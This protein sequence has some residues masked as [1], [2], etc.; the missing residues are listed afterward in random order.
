MNQR[1]YAFWPR[2]RPYSFPIPVT[3]LAINLKSAAERYPK[4]D[5]IVYYDTPI[6][7]ER[8]WRE[9][10]ALAGYLQK[11]VGVK[12]GD[13]VILDMQNSPQWAIAYYAILRANA[14]VVPLN[15]MAVTAELEVYAEDSGATVAFV[16]QELL[17]R[18]RPLVGEQLACV[19]VATYSEYV[20]RATDLT[21]PPAVLAPAVALDDVGIVAWR[22]ALGAGQ[23]PGPVTTGD[24]D[25][26]LL[27]YTSGTTGRPKGCVHT[28]RSVQTTAYSIVAWG[29]AVTAGGK[30]L[31]TLPFFHVTGMTV[32]LNSAFL[33]GSTLIMMTRWDAPTTLNLIE[34]YE[35]D[36]MTAISTMVVDLLAQSD[37]RPE[38]IASLRHLG[39]GGAPLPAAVGEQLQGRL[40]LTYMEGYGLTETISMTHANPPDHTKLQ[41]LGIP[42]FGVDSRVIDPDSGRELGVNET[43]EIVIFGSQVMREYWH[44]PEAT[45]QAFIEIDGKRFF[46][47]G[48]LGFMDDEGYFFMVDRLKRMIN[49]AGFKVW[50]AEVE[51]KLFAHPAIKEACV[52]GSLDARKGEVVKAL[53]VLREG[54]SATPE[55]IIG[56]SRERMSNYKV[57]AIVE[58][59]ESLPRSGTGKVQ[60]REL[61]ERENQKQ[62]AHINN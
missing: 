14:V 6:S 41:C 52:I 18:M 34:R 19:I 51:T 45:A 50:P 31:S 15:P 55:E 33:T 17:E 59:V 32:D 27:P 37:F 58:I 26:A 25:M 24:E 43:G 49:A 42:T 16:G 28:H 22:E 46:R 10:E 40:G 56:W 9:V 35:C 53:V 54:A 44:Q 36:T 8:V 30:I 13:R 3:N 39:G 21:L 4:H 62:F 20:E 11:T 29:G 57:P 38:R 2:R 12:P 5:A 7:Y 48:D 47:T 23:A 60:W 61:Q 1:H